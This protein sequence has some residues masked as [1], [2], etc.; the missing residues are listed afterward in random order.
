MLLRAKLTTSSV[1][2]SGFDGSVMSGFFGIQ[3]F[4]SD[5]GDPDAATQGLLTAAISLG[6]TST[7]PFS[8]KTVLTFASLVER[9]PHRFSSR[10]VFVGSLRP[11]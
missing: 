6:C 4:L 11:G 10:L 9:R 3:S 8:S 5:M 2:Y 7:F 1:L